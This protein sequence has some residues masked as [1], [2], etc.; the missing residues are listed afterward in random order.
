MSSGPVMV[1]TVRRPS[2]SRCSV[3]SRP[4]A[5]LSASTDGSW[6]PGRGRPNSTLGTPAALG[7][8][9]AT[10][11]TLNEPWCSAFLGYGSGVHAPGRREPAAALAAAH[12]LLLGHG[13]ATAALRAALPP[14]AQVA[15]T[16]N[17]AAVRAASER[18]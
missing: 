13:L 3:A 2:P 14:T 16:L 18:P 11:T 1:A 7:D 8:R 5:R 9:V 15:I 6:S 17:L 4:P 12:H 10:W